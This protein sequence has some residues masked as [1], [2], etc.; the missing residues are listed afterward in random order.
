MKKIILTVEDDADLTALFAAAAPIA[1]EMKFEDL[2]VTHKTRKMVKGKSVTS[3]IMDHFTFGAEFCYND[4]LR[5][6]KEAGFRDTSTSAAISRLAADGCIV[7]VTEERKSTNS[8]YR[9]AKKDA[10]H[11]SA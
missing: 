8:R 10:N 4:A 11:V 3:A 7:R 5:W 2:A 9:F 6:I 1:K